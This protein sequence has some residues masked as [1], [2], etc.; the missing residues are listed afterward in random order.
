MRALTSHPIYVHRLNWEPARDTRVSFK[1]EKTVST[2]MLSPL[3]CC[4]LGT[5]PKH[6]MMS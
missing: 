4:V 5:A 6:S 2:S 1:F 3:Q